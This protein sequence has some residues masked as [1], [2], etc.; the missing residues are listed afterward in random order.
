M[1]YL[2]ISDVERAI[3]E[4]RLSLDDAEFLRRMLEECPDPW[5][6]VNDALPETEDDVLVVANGEGKYLTLSGAVCL[7]SYD[8]AG[9]WALTD[10]SWDV[11]PETLNVA[12]WMPIPYPPRGRRLS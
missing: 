3:R 8:P 2:R 10:P 12:Y 11:L 9:G 4:A 5:I 1:T 6:S 7:G